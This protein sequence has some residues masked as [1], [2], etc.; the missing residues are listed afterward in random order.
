[1]KS[2]ERMISAMPRKKGFYGWI[3]LSA[4]AL[5]YFLMCGVLMYPFGVF[6]PSICEEFA[7]GR[8]SVSGAYT[9]MMVSMGLMGPF[10]GMFIARFGSRAAIVLGNLISASGLMLL[11]FHT[12]LWQLYIGYGALVGLGIGLGGFIP[13]TTIANNWFDKR[14]SLALSIV[15]ASGGLGGFLLVPGIM[16]M[17]NSV[18]WR[19]TYLIIFTITLI[20]MV[21]IPGMVVRNKPED[22]GQVQDGAEVPDPGKTASAAST[23]QLY[24]TPV[25]FTLREAIHTPSLWLILC[26]VT[27]QLF[28]MGILTTHQVAFVMDMDIT[29]GVAATSLGMLPG[30]SIVGRLGIGFLGLRYNMRSLAMGSFTVLTL[31]MALV[32]FT[33]SLPMV[34]VYVTVF[35]IGFGAFVVANTGL[36]SVYYG[37][38]SYP[39]I[40]GFIS[41][42][43]LLG[44]SGA[45]IAGII[46]DATGSY[47]L[48]FTAAVVALLVGL[49]C[50]VFARPPGHPTLTGR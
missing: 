42:F 39:K 45:P 19:S 46:Y 4:A 11:S 22:L 9:V 27:A 36:F 3:T 16:A 15:I 23:Q 14:R 8:G 13:T 48:P 18:G 43:A 35:G 25:D 44:S 5:V 1:M 28:A 30:A 20:L 7:W 40:V 17:I 49:A 41:P 6:L 33:K 47:S 31:G 29:A 21:I 24:S 32:L 34:F 26:A 38:T 12:R 10:T 37:Q 50:I 2:G